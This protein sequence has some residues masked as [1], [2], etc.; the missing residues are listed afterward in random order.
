M[1]IRFFIGILT[2]IVKQFLLLK[3]NSKISFFLN[4]GLIFYTNFKQYTVFIFIYWAK[5]IVKQKLYTKFFDFV[6]V[7]SNLALLTSYKK[8]VSLT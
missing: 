6:I 7:L 5:Y 2:L 8:L 1:E 3:V 4:D